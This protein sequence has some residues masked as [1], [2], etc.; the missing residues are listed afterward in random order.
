MDFKTEAALGSE[1]PPESLEPPPMELEES[2]GPQGV[3]PSEA[4][5]D[6]V[7]I[8]L[9]PSRSEA[10]PA[11]Q[12]R[13]IGEPGHRDPEAAEIQSGLEC[14]E[15][16]AW[17]LDSRDAQRAT[18]EGAEESRSPKMGAAGEAAE[19]AA[20]EPGTAR[21]AR[22]PYE[23][24]PA[25]AVESGLQAQAGVSQ[26]ELM[27]E[28]EEGEAAAAAADAP[29]AD[30]P[31]L[32]DL[33][34]RLQRLSPTFRDSSPTSEDALLPASDGEEGGHGLGEVRAPLL[35]PAAPDERPPCP[36]HVAMGHGLGAASRRF[37]RPAQRRKGPG[38]HGLLSAEADREDLLSLL[39]YEGGPPLEPDSPTPLACSDAVAGAS[40]QAGQPR[41]RAVATE[42]TPP[43]PPEGAPGPV[44][45]GEGRG[46]AKGP[47]RWF[48]RGAGAGAQASSSDSSL[49]VNSWETPPAAAAAAA[50]EPGGTAEEP[51][52]SSRREEP[53][54][55]AA[56]ANKTDL[57]S[58]PAYK[59]V[60]GPCEPEDLLDGVIFGAKYLGSTQL[61][62]ERN[63]PTG[64]RMAQAQEAV[65]RVKAPEGESQ[66]MTEV[67]LF[68]STQRI[69]VLLLDSQE[70]LMDHPLQTISYIADI[71]NIVVLMARRKLPRRGDASTE[72]P[73]YKMICHVFHSADA[74]L[75]AQAIGQ[76]FSVAYQHFL[77][78]SGIDPSW[79]HPRRCDAEEEEDDDEALPKGEELYN[80]DLAHFSKQENCKEVV[81]HKQKGEI[82]GVVIVES[83]WG[84]ILPTVVIANLMHRG[85][86]ER[87]GK[88]SIGDRIMSVNGTSLVGLPL[89]ACQNIIRD[90]KN[91]TEVTLNV[92]HCPPVTT[93][94]VRRPDTK[95]PL[96]FCVEN[97]IICSL[98]RGGIAERG[99][100]RVGHRIIE[101]NGQSVV[102]MPH[103]KIIQILT[104]AVSEVHIKTMPASTYRLLTG[105]EQPVFL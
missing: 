35:E 77:H 78:A 79:L 96:G 49:E 80:G 29:E 66:P 74:Q 26:G 33:L 92:V 76:A 9:P 102:A 73:L 56:V 71:G 87:S 16:P 19:A 59:E 4:G 3:A 98:M 97:G 58:F 44:P 105:Q 17:R 47:C 42:E 60:P 22:N 57:S 84:S 34:A 88:L 5:E 99:G 2:P 48:P 45:G 30:Q 52:S 1:V 64:V 83:G 43:P 28:L 25:A 94:I 39:R 12:V 81:L 65:D 75:I 85:A 23:E 10:P 72:K 31:P 46:R 103:E 89:G 53:P 13:E 36:L 40:C 63:P 91:Q 86:A 93:A 100:I 14:T 62:S 15:R 24:A 38:S 6:L 37:L 101:I 70:A 51:G 90:L 69:K 55:S 32:Q 67:D 7:F 21:W 18:E 54:L 27:M 82:L 41:A 68:V 95:Y 50:A 8:Q 20:R 104:Q 61:V 11:R